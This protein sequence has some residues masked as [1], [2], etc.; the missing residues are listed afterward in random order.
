[1]AAASARKGRGTVNGSKK[2]ASSRPSGRGPF[3]GDGREGLGGAGCRLKGARARRSVLNGRKAADGAG[4]WR[5]GAREAFR[6][7]GCRLTVVRGVL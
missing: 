2:R 1:V 4:D 6:E 3:G 5:T 7:Q